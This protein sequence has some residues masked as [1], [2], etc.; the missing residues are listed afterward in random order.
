M[1][2]NHA[3]GVQ[4]VG[5]ALLL[6]APLAG[7][8]AW[9][10]CVLVALAAVAG[11]RLLLL[12]AD[13]GAP[14]QDGFCVGVRCMFAGLVGITAGAGLLLLGAAGL[15]GV[16]PMAHR[17]P[18]AL[19][20]AAGLMGLALYLA[21]AGPLGRRAELRLWLPLTGVTLVAAQ[22]WPLAGAVLCGLTV[23]LGTWLAASS[24]QLARGAVG[25]WR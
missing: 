19:P 14:W 17:L 25:L 24:W 2:R 18:A 21:Q 16:L 8:A 3:R 5:A 11:Q 7:A 9:Q 6:G 10:E 15:S 13:R 20:W 22:A 12:A 1:E 4:L 23:L